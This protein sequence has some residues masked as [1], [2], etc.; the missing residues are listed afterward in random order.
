MRIELAI[1]QAM[2]SG[3]RE[4]RIALHDV[5]ELLRSANGRASNDQVCGLIARVKGRSDRL[6]SSLP[7]LDR[8]LVMQRGCDGC[9]AI[10]EVRLLTRRAERQ[11]RGR[12]KQL[13]VLHSVN[14]L[15]FLLQRRA[16]QMAGI[17]EGELYATDH[18]IRRG[19]VR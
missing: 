8:F 12:F 13:A 5:S 19:L 4:L 7:R 6:E 16:N 10:D 3:P 11:Y 18:N 15:L 14:R 9:R 17:E 2:R 1:R